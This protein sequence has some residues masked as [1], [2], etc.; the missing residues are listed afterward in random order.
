MNRDVQQGSVIRR[1][2]DIVASEMDGEYLV[3]NIE[4]G[5]YLAL[6]NVSARIWEL[7]EQPQTLTALMAVLVK[8]YDVDP[9]LCE[10]EVVAFLRE[11]IA[12]RLIAFDSPA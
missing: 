4:Q 9:H 6:R 12:S 3:L 1:A 2:T 7:L 8:E 5:S 10:R 11:M